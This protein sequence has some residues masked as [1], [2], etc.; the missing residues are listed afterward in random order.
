[1]TK[2]ISYYDQEALDNL[3]K[4]YDLVNVREWTDDE[5]FEVTSEDFADNSDFDASKFKTDD[6]DEILEYLANQWDIFVGNNDDSSYFDFASD[7][8][9][10]SFDLGMQREFI[11][12]VENYIKD[13]Y[14]MGYDF[15]SAYLTFDTRDISTWKDII[16]NSFKSIDVTVTYTMPYWDDSNIADE[17]VTS[18]EELFFEGYEGDGDK[19]EA[20]INVDLSF[21]YND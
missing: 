5:S 6:L 17:D 4:A 1:M 12:K 11:S 19:L 13:N 14:T 16:K 8:E 2:K 9:M 18:G 20:Y 21:E 7:G 15:Q 10:I 3:T